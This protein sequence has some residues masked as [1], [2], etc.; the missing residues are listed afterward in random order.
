MSAPRGLSGTPPV[1]QVTNPT[2]GMARTNPSVLAN[3][4]P[5]EAERLM[6]LAQENL[7]VKWGLYEEMA[8]RG[9]AAF[10]FTQ[11]ASAAGKR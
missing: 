5:K 10:H 4:H 6:T 3:T 2:V 8:T 1:T 11:A 7:E 9:D